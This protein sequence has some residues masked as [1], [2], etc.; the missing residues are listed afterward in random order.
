MQAYI[1]SRT[2]GV[3]RAFLK[4]MHCRGLPNCQDH[5]SGPIF[6]PEICQASRVFAG[7]A[8]NFKR[9]NGPYLGHMSGRVLASAHFTRPVFV[10]ALVYLRACY[11]YK[12]PTSSTHPA[13]RILGPRYP[14]RWRAFWHI[15]AYQIQRGSRLGITA[16]SKEKQ[17]PSPNR[18]PFGPYCTGLKSYQ[19]HGPIF[20][21]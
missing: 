5:H 20:L 7:H 13:A 9:A 18:K 21:S 12:V 8:S 10:R 19:H 1:L 4:G 15:M 2:H 3:Q 14:N 17:S 11:K 16:H 6:L